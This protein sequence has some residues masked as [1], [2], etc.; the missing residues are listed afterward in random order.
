MK[1]RKLL[2][3]LLLSVSGAGLLSAQSD[4]MLSEQLFSR[5]SV[6]PAG[7]GSNENMNIFL[8]SKFYYAG[9][10][11]SPFSAT[12]NLSKYFE[13]ARMGVGGTVSY[14]QSGVSYYQVR[15]QLIYSYNIY[16]ARNHSLTL[17]LGLGVANK[18]FDPSRHVLDDDSERGHE[19]PD[20][21]E[22]TTKF[23]A[24]FGIEYNNPWVTVGA[25]LQHIPGY[26]IEQNTFTYNPAYYAYVRGNIY[27][28]PKFILSPAVTYFYNGNYHV[29]DVNLTGFIG[30]YVW[31][32]L[33]YRIGTTEIVDADG[34]YI[35]PD[36]GTAYVSVGFEWNILR[37]GYVCDVNFGN[38]SNLSY[39]N[40]EIMFSFSIPT[41]KKDVEDNSWDTL[42]NYAAAEASSE[43]Q[44]SSE[45]QPE[46]EVSE[47]TTGEA[48]TS[49]QTSGEAPSSEVQPEAPA[50]GQTSSETPADAQT[51]ATE[52]QGE[53]PAA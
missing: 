39:T 12:I 7:M 34:K 32:G 53:T 27:C 25:S 47:Q 5:I 37:I 30:K 4:F 13:S 6:N 40:H 2:L 21:F 44:E 9:M 8:L 36:A 10:N 35:T 18:M 48:Q 46:A 1:M 28:T 24:S 49:E 14:D 29:G 43:S 50:E 42:D 31:V 20:Q 16:L 23:D 19:F 38:T 17:G 3:V 22:S 11:G 45:A 26:F 52:V 33:G 51:S 15:A 41:K